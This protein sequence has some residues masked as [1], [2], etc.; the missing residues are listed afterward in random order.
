MITNC[1]FPRMIHTSFFETFGMEMQNN[2]NM[3]GF[4]GNWICSQILYS[5]PKDK[6]IISER[7]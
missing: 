1:D 2:I 5:L 3:L 7:V 4:K 6:Y